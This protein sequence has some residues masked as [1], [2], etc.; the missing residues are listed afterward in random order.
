MCVVFREKV[1]KHSTP[2]RASVSAKQRF[3]IDLS[4]DDAQKLVDFIIKRIE[5]LNE[6]CDLKT[7]YPRIEFL[8]KGLLNLFKEKVVNVNV[9]LMAWK[10]YEVSIYASFFIQTIIIMLPLQ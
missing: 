2:I 9:S 4:N 8:I 6:F 1:L 7:A 5:N 3:C 10:V